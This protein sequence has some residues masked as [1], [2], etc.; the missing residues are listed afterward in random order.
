METETS[1]GIRPL[2]CR[3]RPL[4][5]GVRFIPR[6]RRLRGVER[7]GVLV[8]RIVLVCVGDAVGGMERM[9]ADAVIGMGEEIRAYGGGEDFGTLV[10]GEG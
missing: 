4:G 9:V 7:G 10:V 3:V 6:N 5:S 2:V 8:E 1:C